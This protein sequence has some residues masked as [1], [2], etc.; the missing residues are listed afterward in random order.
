MR[1]RCV[2]P[3]LGVSLA[4]LFVFS[5]GCEPTPVRVRALPT[6]AAELPPANLPP[7]LHQRNWT[8][9]KRQGSCVHASIVNHLRWLNQDVLAR[10]WRA[11]YSDGE[12]DSRLRGRLDAAGVDYSFTLKADPRFLDWASMTRRGAILWWKPSHCCTFMGWVER[13]GRQYA[14]ILDNNYPGRFELTPRQQFIRL[15]AGY[16]GFALTVLHP[17]A[18]SLTYRSYEPIL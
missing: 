16:G 9:P 14:A 6:P 13:D 8:G 12:W 10:R 7:S 5:I 3:L 17:P 15:W 4:L 11:T 2:A 1:Q 18:S